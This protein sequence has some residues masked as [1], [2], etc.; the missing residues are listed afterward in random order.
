VFRGVNF[1]GFFG[2]VRCV[3]MVPVSNMSMVPSFFAVAA[4]VMLGCGSVLFGGVFVMVG[5]L[6]M[7]LGSFLICGHSDLLTHTKEEEIEAVARPL[8]ATAARVDRPPRELGLRAT[9]DLKTSYCTV[10]RAPREV[11]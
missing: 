3:Q 5:C 1:S 2:V 10:L 7:M 6:P 11:A 4:L 8:S 9:D